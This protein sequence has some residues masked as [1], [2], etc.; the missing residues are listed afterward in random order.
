LN[1]LHPSTE[2]YSSARRPYQLFNSVTLQQAGGSAIYHGMN[3]QAERRMSGG[4]S[5]NANYTWSKA[6]TDTLLAGNSASFTQNQ[7]ARYLERGDDDWVRRQQLRFSYVY[8][9]PFG[10]GK[11]L[12]NQ[13]PTVAE[14]VLG[15]WQLSGITT[16]STGRRLSPSFSGTD[17]ANTNQFGGRPDRV[18]DGNFD[19]GG[20]RDRIKSGQPIFDL[21]AFVRPAN[22]R[23]SYGNSARNILTGPGAATWNTVL[24]KYFDFTERA[25][26][27]FRWELYNAFNRPNFYNPSTSI[28]G[29]NF[30]LVT[31]A[32]NMRKMLF[33]LRLEY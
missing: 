6:L 17:P 25:R 9:L 18:G 16:M 15:G 33:G 3:I 21:T 32:G 10:R 4:L 8:E 7:Y 30:G 27:Q 28:T 19:S 5:F 14:Y 24:G 1:L 13:L 26:L 2:P 20:M 11:K 31:G 23:G 22:G 12:A 29:G